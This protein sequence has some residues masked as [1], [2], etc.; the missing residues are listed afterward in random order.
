LPHLPTAKA[1]PS[2]GLQSTPMRSKTDQ[3]QK[4][5]VL[6]SRVFFFSGDS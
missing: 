6:S 3:G 5:L 4:T 2:P 1:V